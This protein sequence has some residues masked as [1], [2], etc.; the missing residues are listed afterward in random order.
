MYFLLIFRV[1]LPICRKKSANRAGA[2]A[3]TVIVFVYWLRSIFRHISGS[4]W[5]SYLIKTFSMFMNSRCV[6]TSY[7]CSLRR[8]VTWCFIDPTGITKGPEWIG[9]IYEITTILR[10][11]IGV[12]TNPICP[13]TPPHL[14]LIQRWLHLPLFNI[15]L[16]L[17]GR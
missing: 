11:S 6:C 13:C 2:G 12:N 8:R 14:D 10:Y 3:F 16:S 4:A 9:W 17:E 7:L 5:P 1:I 15:L